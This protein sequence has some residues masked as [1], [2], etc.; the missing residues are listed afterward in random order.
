MGLECLENQK[1]I[2]IE[3]RREEI[4]CVV[5]SDLKWSDKHKQHFLVVWF[6]VEGKKFQGTVTW[7]DD[8]NVPE[9][10]EIIACSGWVCKI[11]VDKFTKGRKLTI[12]DRIEKAEDIEE[13]KRFYLNVNYN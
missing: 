6:I 1:I 5:N 10:G 9:Q 3:K 11:N 7:E 4:L 2:D 8:N 12:S 13:L